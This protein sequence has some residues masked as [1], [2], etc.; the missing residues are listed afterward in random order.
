MQKSDAVRRRER[1]EH[2]AQVQALSRAITSAI[3][4][5]E[6]NDLQE[7]QTH[8]AAQE[9]ICNRLSAVKAT[10]S[11]I[12]MAT[13]NTGGGENPDASLRQEIIEAHIALTQLNRVY[14]ALLKRASRTV[15]L[16]AALYQGQGAGYNRGPSH[17][18]QRHSWSCEV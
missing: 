11:S 4:A 18:P 5:I 6:K 2:L 13:T 12:T 3:S 10:L 15:G 14:A 17:L 16:I 9:T 1:L 7:F 8:L